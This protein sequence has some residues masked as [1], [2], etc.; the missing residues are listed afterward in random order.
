M[1]NEI[2]LIALEKL[3]TGYLER[4]NGGTNEFDP[5]I[6]WI[7]KEKIRAFNAL[8]GQCWLVKINR[9]TE[10]EKCEPYMVKFKG[11]RILRGYGLAVK[12]YDQT[13]C[14][15]LKEYDELPTIG[16]GP[17]IIMEKIN[18]IF[19]RAGEIGCIYLQWV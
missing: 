14:D 6:N 7:S 4:H 16:C 19:N 3:S 15:L 2:Q 13:L 18:S 8:H 11:Q 1:N 5:S 9:Y 10:E 17:S 12:Q